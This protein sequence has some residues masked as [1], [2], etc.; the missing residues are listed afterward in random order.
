M[1]SIKMNF[2]LFPVIDS[3]PSTYP[4]RSK[5]NIDNEIVGIQKSYIRICQLQEKIYNSGIIQCKHIF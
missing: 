3:D 2:E 4:L 5:E 1:L